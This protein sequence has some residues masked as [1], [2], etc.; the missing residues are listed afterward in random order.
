MS[1]QQLSEL[2]AQKF[3]DFL[4]KQEVNLSMKKYAYSSGRYGEGYIVDSPA[5]KMNRVK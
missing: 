5:G 3:E 4:R 2:Q 1:E